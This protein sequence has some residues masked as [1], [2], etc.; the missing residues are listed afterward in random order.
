MLVTK[1]EHAALVVEVDG[2]R[3]VIDPGG[4]T[5]PLTDVTDVEGIVITH[6]HPD[7]WTP[8]QIEGLLEANPGARILGPEGVAHAL[9]EVGFAV[10]TVSDGDVVEVGPFT[11]RFA[12]TDHAVIHETLPRVDNTGVLVN[13][14][15]FHPGD[16]YTVPP[17]DVPV[18]AAPIGAP[19]LKIGE[20]MDYAAAVKPGRA[21][22]IHEKTLSE[23]GLGMHVDRIRAVVE[24]AGGDV[25]VLA[26]GE[27]LEL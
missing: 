23:T 1:Y 4:F 15:L 14:T 10:E 27:S 5:R 2:Q 24:A 26:P 17:F 13:D 25:V 19:W 7:H 21:F 18:L 8:G 6:Q 9:G 20:A 22:P 12:G 11:L 3:L 16:S